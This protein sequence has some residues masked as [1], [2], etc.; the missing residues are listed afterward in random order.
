MLPDDEMKAVVDELRG[1][2]PSPLLGSSRSGVRLWAWAEDV[3]S[4]LHRRFPALGVT[5]G[6]LRYP[7][8]VPERHLDFDTHYARIAQ[9]DPTEIGVALD[10]PLTVACGHDGHHRLM[11]TNH[12]GTPRVLATN[13]RITA[14]VVDPSTRRVVG[15]STM[16]QTMPGVSFRVAPNESVAIPLVVGTASVDPSLG[17]TVPAGA[18][19]LQA[20]LSMRDEGETGGLE[21]LTPPLRFETV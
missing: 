7:E 2:D 14:H 5:V 6:Y 4:Q 1:M 8:R 20:T 17:Y 18:W 19:D 9:L 11:V 10:G 13:G 16:A 15:I 3:A 12:S 21:Y